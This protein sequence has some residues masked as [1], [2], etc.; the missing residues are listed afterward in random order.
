MQAEHLRELPD[1]FRVARPGSER[2]H[3]QEMLGR[4]GEDAEARMVKYPGGRRIPARSDIGRGLLIQPPPGQAQLCG[5]GQCFLKDDAMRLEQGIDV[6]G[7]PARVVRKGH[8][9]TAEHVEVSHHAA[10]CKPVAEAAESVFDARA[11]EEGRRIA[12]AASIS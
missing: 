11:V 7:G 10:S 1:I 8:R 5:H 12:H 9:S 4:G 2:L 3:S 6:T